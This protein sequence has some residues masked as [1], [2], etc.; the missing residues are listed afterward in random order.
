MSAWE[1]EQQARAEARQCR[2]E[3]ARL[4]ARC[5]GQGGLLGLRAQGL[6]GEGGI[7]SKDITE[8]VT[9]R[10]GNTLESMRARSYRL[11]TG[12]LEGGRTVVR[13]AV[14]LRLRN[15]AS[16][17]WTPAG[18]VLVGP[19]GMEW[20]VLGVGPLEPIAPGWKDECSPLVEAQS[21][22][23]RRPARGQVARA[24]VHSIRGGLTCDDSWE[25]WWPWCW[26]DVESQPR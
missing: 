1:G 20:K 11:D 3:K 25:S 12:R 5:S 15:N 10:P 16:T 2:E 18:A 7:V 23:L 6:L 19:R 9:S 21:A 22:C 17:P 8:S 26:R 13:L 4:E 24:G 14:E